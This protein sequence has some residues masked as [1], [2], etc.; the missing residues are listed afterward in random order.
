MVETKVKILSTYKYPGDT[1]SH[2]KIAI[3]E[4]TYLYRTSAYVI[5]RFRWILDNGGGFKALNY[6]KKNSELIKE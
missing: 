2:V 4:K 5:N 1:D 3:G 6:L